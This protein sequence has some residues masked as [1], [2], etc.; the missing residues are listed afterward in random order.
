[1]ILIAVWFFLSSGSRSVNMEA[2]SIIGWFCLWEAA[3]IAF[4]D[5]PEIHRRQISFEHAINAEIIVES[6]TDCI[7]NP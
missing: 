5:R 3:N 6:G 4:L 2:L 7:Q 1:M